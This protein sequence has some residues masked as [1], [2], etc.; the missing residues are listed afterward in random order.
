M[1]NGK[2]HIASNPF[3]TG[4]G[5][6]PP[7]LAGREDEKHKLY[8]LLG[9]TVGGEVVTS[10]VHIFITNRAAVVVDRRS[11]DAVRIAGNPA[12]AQAEWRAWLEKQYYG[13]AGS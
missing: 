7:Y 13:A 8:E 9:R 11:L 4:H 12:R 2:K 3:T 5:K 6:V 1:G 10:N